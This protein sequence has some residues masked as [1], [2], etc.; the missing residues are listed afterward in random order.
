[1]YDWLYVRMQKGESTD[2]CAEFHCN[3]KARARCFVEMALA[4]IN[5]PSGLSRRKSTRNTGCHQYPTTMGHRRGAARARRLH[6]C[7]SKRRN[8]NVNRRSRRRNSILRGAI[9]RPNSESEVFT[10]WRDDVGC[11]TVWS[12]DLAQSVVCKPSTVR[13]VLNVFNATEHLASNIST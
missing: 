11:E 10:G 4:K 9:P 12:A 8:L 13:R 3:S 7:K 2:K 5:S 6:R 1:M